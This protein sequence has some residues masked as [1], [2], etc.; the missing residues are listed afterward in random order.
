[1][2]AQVQ[3]PRHVLSELLQNA[4][5]AGATAAAVSI[6][7]SR[8]IFTH[9]GE[10]FSRENFASLCEFGVSNKRTLHTIGFWGIGF[11]STFS[12]GRTVRL[13]TP[14]LV[15]EFDA[16]RFTLPRWVDRSPL[17]A[18]QTEIS[19]EVQ[20]EDRLRQVWMSLTEWQKSPTSLLF[21]RNIRE[22][23]LAG[24]VT[25]FRVVAPGP[26]EDSEWVDFERAGMT[27][28]YLLAHSPMVQMPPAVVSEIAVTRQLPFTDDLP[29]S[30]VDIVLGVPG[31]LFVVL[32]TAVET[33]LPF[34]INAP[35]L[36]DAA[37]HG[38]TE[39]SISPTNRWF[40]KRAGELAAATMMG[41]VRNRSLDMCSRAQAYRLLPK[42]AGDGTSLA[43][44]S[45][46]HTEVAFQ[47]TIA[48]QPILLTEAGQV[49][50][51]DAVA[52]I[53][54]EIAD[55]WTPAQAVEIL[56]SRKSAPLYTG[57]ESASVQALSHRQLVL[58]VDE[59]AVFKALQQKTPTVPDSFDKLFALWTYIAD[60]YT[61]HR[62]LASPKRLKLVPVLG[63]AVLCAGEDVVRVG[64]APNGVDASD[65]SVLANRLQVAD[66][67]WFADVAR[68]REAASI[69]DDVALA[70]KVSQVS[71]LMQLMGVDRATDLSIAF[72]RAADQLLLSKEQSLQAYTR[73]AH[74]AA[75]LEISAG[76]RFPF[77]TRDGMVRRASDGIL[78][79]LDGTLEE[80]VPP[81]LRREA[82]LHDAYFRDLDASH[83]EAWRRWFESGKSRLLGFPVPQWARLSV[84]GHEQM[85][86]EAARRG[87]PE[88]LPLKYATE[89]FQLEDYDFATPYWNHW[90]SLSKE[91]DRAWI[92]IG[93]AIL[94]QPHDHWRDCLTAK[95]T[96]MS[97]NHQYRM[98][99]DDDLSPSW[100]MRLCDLPCLRDT[101][102]W[103]ALPG[104]LLRRTPE[105]EALLDVERFVDARWDN[106]FTQSMLDRWG[107]RSSVTD[108]SQILDRLRVLA[109]VESPPVHEVEK[110]YL[111]LDKLLAMGSGEVA[112][113]VREA[114]SSQ[115]LI[116][117]EDGFW[118][119]S[120]SVFI[121]GDEDVP[122]AATVRAQ[123]RDLPLWHRVGVAERPTVDLVVEWLRELPMGDRLPEGD[124][125]RIRAVLGRHAGRIWN[126]CGAWLNLDGQ[127]VPTTGLKWGLSMSTLVGHAHLHSWARQ[128]TA[129]LKMLSDDEVAVAPFSSLRSL[130][131][132][133]EEVIDPGVISGG[134]V[135]AAGWLHAIGQHLGRVVVAEDDPDS[136]IRAQAMRLA[137]TRCVEVPE[138]KVIP[139]LDG[140]PAGIPRLVPVVWV[141]TDLL[142]SPMS[143][144]KLARVVPECIGRAFSDSD[145]RAAVLYAYDR[146]ERQI[147]DY[148]EANFEL[149]E[150]PTERMAL[151]MAREPGAE[152]VP[153][154][155]A[156]GQDHDVVVD[157]ENIS[158]DAVLTTATEDSDEPPVEAGDGDDVHGDDE[159]S[160]RRSTSRELRAV[161]RYALSRGYQKRLDG[162]FV[163]ADGRILNR[164]DT[165][166][167]LWVIVEPGSDESNYLWVK[168]HCLDHKPMLIPAELWAMIMARP[169]SYTLVLVG[170]SGAF[171]ELGGELLLAQHVQGRLVLH[172]SAYLLERRMQ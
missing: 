81:D 76:P 36:Q 155:S 61:R 121:R 88:P 41:W 51:S 90:Q 7:D 65:W 101:R 63:R 70:R 125:Q 151:D 130:A 53:P 161:D 94:S 78:C 117:T 12:L 44:S 165:P 163:H 55:V 127:W 73:F 8:F 124:A 4:D 46:R 20:D 89:R 69:D 169:K 141:G 21:F 110:Y 50:G 43:T 170:S 77:V 85:S 31:R 87:Y 108:P 86:A 118:V 91:D 9:N 162:S 171:E 16:N 54:P 13:R 166:R 107:V 140:V 80:L 30:R 75:R 84:R 157:S 119:D 42:P 139:Y 39:P 164:H 71:G 146:T 159:S 97:G 82:L 92:R 153:R 49:L 26:V 19:V 28:R 106:P 32:P 17:D 160:A 66:E 60:A 102:G 11:K 126:Q 74:L 143:A 144:G 128:C 15:V 158:D 38:I 100:I 123:L 3:S 47:A 136:G 22:L 6:K 120:G 40:L 156:G 67:S 72:V 149:E 116:F 114:M 122:G 23:D 98:I 5:D 79:D 57:I 105:T 145:I 64:A 99:V 154:G 129:D 133:I 95:I 37:R 45:T 52:A 104:E 27:E 59:P 103:S 131:S 1:M 172:P 138:I 135:Y 14:T 115:K 148:F 18:G 35:F 152:P 68:R 96:Q 113:Q 83:R 33:S 147:R 58:M 111:R 24:N 137:G 29:P 25:R 142:V 168:E 48:G 10:D 62:F 56:D 109:A 112:E 167:Y 132:E 150:L 93:E 2:F 34:A 134:R